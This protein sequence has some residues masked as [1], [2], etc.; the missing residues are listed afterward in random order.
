MRICA[1]A[2]MVENYSSSLVEVHPFYASNGTISLFVSV[3]L[4]VCQL[5]LLLLIPMSRFYVRASASIME[6][7]ATTILGGANALTSSTVSK[8][9]FNEF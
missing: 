7:S 9:S 2:Q 8:T 1:P 4:V 6:V 5:L 3:L